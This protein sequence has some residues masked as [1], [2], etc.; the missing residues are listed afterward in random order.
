MPEQQPPQPLTESELSA[1]LHHL[2]SGVMAPVPASGAQVRGQAVRRRRNRR[3]ALSAT[4]LAAAALTIVATGVP[5]SPT[6]PA[7]PPATSVSRTP[8]P[9]PS[10]APVRRI[11]IDLNSRFLAVEGEEYGIAG[12]VPVCPIGE[13]MVTVTAKYPTLTVPG[14]AGVG[15]APTVRR[16]AVTFTDRR[17]HERLLFWALDRSEGL[18]SVGHGTSGSIALPYDTGKEVYDVVGPGTRVEIKGW[19]AA[20]AQPDSVCSDRRP[21]T[22]AR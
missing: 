13:T 20:N 1:R 22:D 9:A 7:T 12:P 4:V 2:A 16:W 14:P 17:H 3:A 15:G 21:I 19:Q 10:P 8:R 11:T 5:G 18:D 6:A